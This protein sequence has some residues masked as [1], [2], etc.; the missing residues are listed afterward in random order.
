MKKLL[1]GILVFSFILAFGGCSEEKSEK[2]RFI[3]ATVEATCLV[4][5]SENIFDP[6]LEEEAKAIYEKHGFDADDEEAMQA[7]TEKYQDDPDVNAA[8]EEALEEC[9]GDFIKAFEGMEDMELNLEGEGMPEEITEEVP[10]EIIE[11]A[12]EEELAE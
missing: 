8:I 2:E 7:L 11:E 9:A 5:Q 1:V 12:A 3:D 10:E 6:A 4:F